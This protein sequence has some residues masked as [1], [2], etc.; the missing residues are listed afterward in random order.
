M[1]NKIAGIE[2][3]FNA[4]VELTA[5]H[6]KELQDIVSKIC[7]HYESENPGRVMWLFGYGD[8]IEYMPILEDDPR[9]MGFDENILAI[10]C[11]EREKH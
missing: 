10:E 1:S 7:K 4:P 11:A 9:P 2:I 5:E 3:T 6:Q 8:R